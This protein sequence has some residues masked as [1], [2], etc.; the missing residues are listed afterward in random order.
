M[1]Y[2]AK[3]SFCRKDRLQPQTYA[4]SVC[5]ATCCNSHPEKLMI[6]LNRHSAHPT[7]EELSHMEAVAENLLPG[8][9]WRGPASMPQHFHLHQV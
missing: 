5:W 9:S 6:V 7:P 3:C 8:Q 2:D 4:D 1:E